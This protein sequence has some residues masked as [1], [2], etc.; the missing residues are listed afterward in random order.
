MGASRTP[1]VEIGNEPDY[2]GWTAST[3]MQSLYAANNALSQSGLH[4]LQITMAGL[5][6]NDQ[7]YLNSMGLIGSVSWETTY[8]DGHF[9]T[10][11]GSPTYGPLAPDDLDTA[12]NGLLSYLGGITQYQSEFPGKGLIVGEWGWNLTYMTEPVRQSYMRAAVSIARQKQLKA[13]I[14]EEI[15]SGDGAAANL[16]NT[17]AW[18]TY[19]DAVNAP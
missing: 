17:A 3:Y 13:L 15:G 10:Y 9:Y 14:V 11:G 19:A 1:I 5:A 4:N 8:A 7:G 2:N 18:Q 16:K 12:H 6:D